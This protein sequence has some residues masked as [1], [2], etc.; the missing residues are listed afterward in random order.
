MNLALVPVNIK[1]LL[2]SRWWYLFII[3]S[4]SIPLIASLSSDFYTYLIYVYSITPLFF[5]PLISTTVAMDRHRGTIRNFFTTPISRIDYLLSKFIQWFII[6]LFYVLI[7]LPV[8]LCYCSIS[9]T[10]GAL[11]ISILLSFLIFAFLTSLG[12]FISVL[13]KGAALAQ[14][15]V[16]SFFSLL[17]YLAYEL[18]PHALYYS[19]NLTLF[20]ASPPIALC[21]ALNIWSYSSTPLMINHIECASP[22][23][24][25]LFLLLLSLCLF[26]STCAIFCRLQNIIGHNTIKGK[27][28]YAFAVAAAL[29]LPFFIPV[30]DYFISSREFIRASSS[31]FELVVDPEILIYDGG[32]IEATIRIFIPYGLTGLRDVALTL[33]SQDLIFMRSDFEFDYLNIVSDGGR[34]FFDIP[35]RMRLENIRGLLYGN[36][37]IDITMVS[38]FRSDFLTTNVRI[39]NRDAE[40]VVALAFMLSVAL[41]SLVALISKR[42]LLYE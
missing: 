35:V 27:E 19:T 13:I 16:S 8:S 1:L 23:N 29:L 2:R 7:T 10:T 22:I 39:R 17:F 18:Y 9:G 40:L 21:D 12:I 11:L 41:P 42:R 33:Y 14:I 38:R 5:L 30:S 20:R 34:A 31:D 36:Y 28:I 32:M 4:A 26:L 3:F 24:S 6:G 15:A 37:E 25:T